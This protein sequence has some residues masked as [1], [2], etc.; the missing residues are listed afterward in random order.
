MQYRL[1]FSDKQVK[2]KKYEIN[3]LMIQKKNEEKAYLTN[4]TAINKAI[5][6]A[7]REEDAF[8]PLTTL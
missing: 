2:K 4:L 8:S 5:A 1:F 7:K 3:P 6:E